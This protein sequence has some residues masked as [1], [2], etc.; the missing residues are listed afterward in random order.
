MVGLRGQGSGPKS[1]DAFTSQCSAVSALDTLN[2]RF[3]VALQG[4]LKVRFDPFVNQDSVLLQLHFAPWKTKAS[5]GL[6]QSH[7]FPRDFI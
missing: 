3:L 4:Q 5:P 2:F 6:C 1:R 7:S